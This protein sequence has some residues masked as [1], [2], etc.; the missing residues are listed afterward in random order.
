MLRP[1]DIVIH[2]A[3]KN[4]EKIIDET[5]LKEKELFQINSTFHDISVV[6]NNIGRFLKYDNTYQAGFINSPN[7]KGNLFYINY[8]LIP[9]LMNKNI[10]N[11]LLVGFGSGIIVNQFEKIFK[12]LDRIDVVDIEEN[13]FDIAK[14]YF[15]FKNS[16]KINFFLQDAL[17]Y[18]KN[19]KRKY[20]LI[21]VDVAGNEGI[22]ERFLSVEYLNLIKKNLKK[23]GVFIS[24]LP[25]SRDI[26]NKKNKVIL[27]LLDDYRK[28]FN[29]VDIY[30]G[31]TSNKLYYKTFYNIDKIVYDIT[32]LILISSDFEYKISSNYKKLEDINVDIKPYLSD[33]AKR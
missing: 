26:F 4:F 12:K 29:F 33:L 32:N 30:N 6:E 16:E 20:D 7:Y 13:I 25:S 22:D 28:M 15:N 19:N 31:E 23:K 11:I 1:E 5:D 10:K 2:K 17:I 8:F 9:Y 14:N 3:D 27:S 21:I 18:L 24:N